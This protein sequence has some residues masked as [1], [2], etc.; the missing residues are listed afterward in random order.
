MYEKQMTH[1][2][3]EA[4]KTSTVFKKKNYVILDG[5]YRY[6]MS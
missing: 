1:A 2:G 6:Q 5:K 4:N 3:R